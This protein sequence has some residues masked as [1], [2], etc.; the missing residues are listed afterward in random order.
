MEAD[1]QASGVVGLPADNRAGVVVA[2]VSTLVPLTGLVVAMRF[3][4]RQHL[5]NRIGLDD[6][7]VLAALVRRR[8]CLS[9]CIECER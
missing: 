6:W 2:V 3:Y 7:V 9:W 4:S 8:H 5:D 1:V